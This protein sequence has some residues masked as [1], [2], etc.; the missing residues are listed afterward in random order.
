MFLGFG[1]IIGQIERNMDILKTHRR[2]L[3][4]IMIKSIRPSENAET[5]TMQKK[6]MFFSCFCILLYALKNMV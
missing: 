1:D 4:L 2:L 6:A 5:I 3:Q